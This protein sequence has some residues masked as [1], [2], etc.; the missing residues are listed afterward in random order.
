VFT[1]ITAL[2]DPTDYYQADID[3]TQSIDLEVADDQIVQMPY[4]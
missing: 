2:D 1:T 4:H 3:F